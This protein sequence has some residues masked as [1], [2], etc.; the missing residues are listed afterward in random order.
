MTKMLLLVVIASVLSVSLGAPD[1]CEAA[2]IQE[3]SLAAEQGDGFVIL[4]WEPYPRRQCI[5]RYLI[6]VFLDDEGNAQLLKNLQLNNSNARGVVVGELENGL[7]YVFAVTAFNQFG[8]GL[9]R[10]DAVPGL[11]EEGE[12]MAPGQL[13]EDVQ[14]EAGKLEPVPTST[15]TPAPKEDPSPKPTPTPT[16]APKEDPS[17]EPK[18]TPAPAPKEDPSPEPKKDDK[19]VD[20]SPKPKQNRKDLEPAAVPAP[21]VVPIKQAPKEAIVKPQELKEQTFD[22]K[23]VPSQP[24]F[25]STRCSTT[26][27]CVKWRKSLLNTA[28][29]DYFIVGKEYRGGDAYLI[30]RGSETIDYSAGLV[31]AEGFSKDARNEDTCVEFEGLEPNNFYRFQVIGANQIGRAHV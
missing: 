31:F 14:E 9:S 13:V 25:V 18:P 5:D 28:P 7:N 17:P 21:I 30:S 27:C 16:P 8:S 10:V 12:T 3:N 23:S 2:G 26:K 11:L 4:T 1:G 24:S 6:S 19:K 20:K 29:S 15:P 22:T